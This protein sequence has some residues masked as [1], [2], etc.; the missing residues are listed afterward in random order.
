MAENA[1]GELSCFLCREF[2]D[3]KIVLVLTVLSSDSILTKIRTILRQYCGKDDWITLNLF[4]AE[5]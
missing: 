4:Y 2:P 5:D 3:S 1:E